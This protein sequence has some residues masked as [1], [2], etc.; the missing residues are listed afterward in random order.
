MHLLVGPVPC[1]NE[2]KAPLKTLIQALLEQ[3]TRTS[4]N[5]NLQG[6][7]FE[8][9]FVPESLNNLRPP[10]NLLYFIDNE[11]I[12]P[13]RLRLKSGLLP[14]ALYPSKGIYAKPLCKSVCER[15]TIMLQGL[16]YGSRLAN[17]PGAGDNLNS[18]PFL[19]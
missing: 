2:L 9:I 5:Q 8:R 18:K 16:L 6:N 3:E 7:I 1:L 17:L 12:F 15:F 4:E 19:I 10:D 14:L 11:E 13:K